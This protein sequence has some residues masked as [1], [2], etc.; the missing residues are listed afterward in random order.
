V[1]VSP[2]A[3][4]MKKQFKQAE[5]RGARAVMLIGPEE[6]AAGNAVIKSMVSGEQHVCPVDEV[7]D[8]LGS[9]LS[10]GTA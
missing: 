6:E 3:A 5:E 4:R 7:V 1:N 2:E 9:L 8:F 10:K